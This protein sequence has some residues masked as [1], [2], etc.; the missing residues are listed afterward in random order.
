MNILTVTQAS[1]AINLVVNK[2][3]TQEKLIAID[4]ATNSKAVL[5]GIAAKSVVADNTW[6]II[7]A[8]NVFRL[9][10][11]REKLHEKLKPGQLP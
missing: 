9:A 5:A 7:Q 2:C 4:D 10:V 6:T 8:S 3:N 1:N 11:N